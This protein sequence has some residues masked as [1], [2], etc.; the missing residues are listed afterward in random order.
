MMQ[1]RLGDIVGYAADRELDFAAVPLPRRWYLLRVR[2]N[3][4][5]RVMQ[6]FERRQ[7]S[8]YYPTEI[9]TI[10]RRDPRTSARKPHLGRR[11]VTP[12]IHGLLFLPDF[13]L[14]NLEV[15]R[16]DDV[17][18]YLQF[19]PA[20][21][22]LS[23]EAFAE[24]RAIEALL[25][26]PR[27]QRKFALGDKVRFTEGLFADFVGR[28]DRLDSKGRLRVFLDAVERG[29]TVIATETQVELVGRATRGTI[30]GH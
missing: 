15:L 25:A 27:G 10:D 21:G 3:R 20:L 16:V 6:A 11:I 12:M 30:A 19:G 22:S 2:P 1:Y 18:G 5:A 4:E 17:L 28:I 29:V 7:I 8:A 14:A 26:I 24:L 23:T 9:R 13:E